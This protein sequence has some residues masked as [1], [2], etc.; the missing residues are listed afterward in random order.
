MSDILMLDC[1]SA[2]I[3]GK[4]V[5]NKI[6]FS[7]SAGEAAVLLGPSGCGKSSLLSVCCGSL[8]P[9]TGKIVINGYSG[10][11]P[12]AYLLKTGCVLSSDE[13]HPKQTVFELLQKAASLYRGIDNIQIEDTA[14]SLGLKPH[15][16]TKYSELTDSL[17]KLV[18]LA[19]AF[20]GNPR[21]ILLDNPFDSLNPDDCAR[22]S[23]LIEFYCRKKGAA[24]LIAA[25]QC[26]LAE[27]ICSK[28]IVL[29]G[30]VVMD[31]I[32]IR[33]INDGFKS[34]S[35]RFS[36]TVDK[37]Y[38]ASIVLSESGY[39]P[40][41][42]GDIVSAIFSRKQ[43]NQVLKE[44]IKNGISI[45]DVSSSE[46]RLSDRYTDALLFMGGYTG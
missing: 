18:L 12:P 14:T 38:S 19:T 32:D 13:L 39:S 44:L 30:G 24:A 34:Q 15:L 28:A 5:L 31:T 29:L 10:E 8:K 17:R 21:L 37:P 2:Q 4:Q 11:M 33:H 6:S 42:S 16:N 23:S 43:L 25:G 45:Y 41:A 1:I 22:L 27:K 26:E 20:V 35:Y 40:K 3:E 46:D 36:F 7:V 9:S